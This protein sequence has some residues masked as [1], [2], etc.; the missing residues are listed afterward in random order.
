MI[1]CIRLLFEHNTKCRKPLLSAIERNLSEDDFTRNLGVGHSS[2]RNILVHLMNSESYWI[3]QVLKKEIGKV[4]DP[5]EVSNVADVRNL[6][7]ERKEKTEKYL[8]NLIENDLLN[9]ETVP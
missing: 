1:D 4:Y 8:S 9:V 7:E 2:I 5:N 6:F 3:D